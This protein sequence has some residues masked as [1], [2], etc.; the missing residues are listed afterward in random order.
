LDGFRRRGD[1]GADL[2]LARRP[3]LKKSLPELHYDITKS[4]QQVGSYINIHVE[5]MHGRKAM[6][7]S[8]RQSLHMSGTDGARPQNTILDFLGLTID[9]DTLRKRNAGQLINLGL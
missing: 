3:Y 6:S 1:N 8:S 4:P 9:T 2:K 5:E 7:T